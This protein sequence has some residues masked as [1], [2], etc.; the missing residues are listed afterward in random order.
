[1]HAEIYIFYLQCFF[2]IMDLKDNQ[3]AHIVRNAIEEVRQ[4]DTLR[5]FKIEYNYLP[6]SHSRKK[7]GKNKNSRE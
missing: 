6:K 7:V 5:G 4:C 3:K 1:M 2:D